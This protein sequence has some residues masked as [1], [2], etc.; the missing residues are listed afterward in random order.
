M[1]TIHPFVV[2]CLLVFTVG[3]LF[4]S[5][6]LIDRMVLLLLFTT[7]WFFGLQQRN[8]HPSMTPIESAR[9]NAF[10]ERYLE[11]TQFPLPPSPSPSPP[12]PP[13]PPPSPPPPLS[14]ISEESDL[15]SSDSGATLVDMDATYQR[16]L[17][18]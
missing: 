11:P 1:A 15:S 13:S 4:K 14:P 8:R 3:M 7:M 12:P 18:L 2:I 10:P 16:D 6:T 5:A 9:R 17:T